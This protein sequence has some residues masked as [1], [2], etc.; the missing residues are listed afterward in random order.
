MEVVH[1]LA[2]VK[3]TLNAIDFFTRLCGRGLGSNNVRENHPSCRLCPTSR[4]ARKYTIHDASL[5]NLDFICLA[6]ILSTAKA[7]P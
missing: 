6:T 1:N 4:A 2:L 3:G 5:E 7:Y